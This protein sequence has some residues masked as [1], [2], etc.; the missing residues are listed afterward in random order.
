MIDQIG[1]LLCLIVVVCK[2][3]ER[4]HAIFDGD[5]VGLDNQ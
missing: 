4:S 2:M 1:Q 5:S 3:L